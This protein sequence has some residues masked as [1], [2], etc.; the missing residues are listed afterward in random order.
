MQSVS[1]DFLYSY[2]MLLGYD[3]PSP[4]TMRYRT[5]NERKRH[6]I[7][8]FLSSLFDSQWRSGL[9]TWTITLC[10]QTY[11]KESK[12][13]RA[14]NSCI[15]IRHWVTQ[16]VT[17][18]HDHWRIFSNNQPCLLYIQLR[19]ILQWVEFENIITKNLLCCANISTAPS[20]TSSFDAHE[21]YQ[22]I[23]SG[24]FNF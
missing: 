10:W 6:D 13:R 23:H 16:L 12:L 24:S 4:D 11:E 7:S 22:Q 5:I 21:T 20:K 18:D 8:S 1:L 15:H 2:W 14:G 3:M 9:Q 19:R 17:N